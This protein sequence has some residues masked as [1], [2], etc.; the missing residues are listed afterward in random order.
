MLIQKDTPPMDM[1]HPELSSVISAIEERVVGKHQVVKRLLTAVLARG[2]VLLDDVPGMGKTTLAKTAAAAIGLSYRRIQFTPDLLPSDVTG[3]SVFHPGTRQF[4]FQP[5]PVFTQLLL[6]DE[7][8]RASP[9]TQSALLEVMEEGQVTV[10]GVA[11]PV[12]QP[13]TVIATENPIEYEGTFPLPV[14]QLNRFFFRLRM[15]YPQHQDEVALLSQAEP[16]HLPSP[17]LSQASL[18]KFQIQVRQVHVAESIRHYMADLAARTRQHPELMLGMSP[19]ATVSLQNASRAWAFLHARS[20]V[21]PDDVR[22]LFPDVVA[23][24]IILSRSSNADGAEILDNIV[25][26]VAPPTGDLR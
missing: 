17:V 4:E 12:P 10:D 2:H 18:A 22:V 6:A 14:S 11:R 20:Y 21:I 26:S 23:H 19:R 13:F 9:R 1:I 8:N 5:G 7:I 3:V 25:R 15:G 16:N 24:R